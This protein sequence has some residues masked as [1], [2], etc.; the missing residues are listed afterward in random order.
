MHQKMT[1]PKVFG[2]YRGMKAHEYEWSIGFRYST[3]VDYVCPFTG[4]EKTLVGQRT[5]QS[6]SWRVNGD[7]IPLYVAE[8]APHHARIAENWTLDFLLACA[9]F[10]FAMLFLVF[11]FWKM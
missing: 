10:C 2:I 9:V 4:E 11:L 3:T 5:S 7:P 1:S 8:A 6:Q